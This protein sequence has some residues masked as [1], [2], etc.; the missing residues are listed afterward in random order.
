MLLYSP[1]PGDFSKVFSG[2][3]LPFDRDIPIGADC[4]VNQPQVEVAAT[5][6]CMISQ[7]GCIRPENA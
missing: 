7:M 4:R 3:L 5:S 1:S 6:G 2:A